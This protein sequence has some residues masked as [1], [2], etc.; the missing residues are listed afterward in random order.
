MLF[1]LEQSMLN[2]KLKQSILNN[3][4]KKYLISLYEFIKYY[5]L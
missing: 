4:L 3:K 5:P 2:K 1:L